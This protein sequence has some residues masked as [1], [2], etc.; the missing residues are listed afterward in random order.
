MRNLVITKDGYL[1]DEGG[2]ARDDTPV[3]GQGDILNIFHYPGVPRTSLTPVTRFYRTEHPAVNVGRRA[4]F[5]NEDGQPKWRD[6]ST[7]EEYD[8]ELS[9][10]ST[11]LRVTY[12]CLLY[13]SP[14]PRD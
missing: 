7:D 10:P 11:A 14:S 13:T 3:N 6:L 12:S 2:Y 5:P 1:K 4:F 8:W 9:A